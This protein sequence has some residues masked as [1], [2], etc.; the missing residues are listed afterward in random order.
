MIR[1]RLR[2]ALIGALLCLWAHSEFAS[3]HPLDPALLEIRES[4]NATIDVLWRIPASL[5]AGGPLKPIFPRRCATLAAPRASPTGARVTVRWQ[6]RCGTAGLVGQ[7][8]GIDGLQ[9]RRTDALVRIHLSDGRLVQSVLRGDAPFLAVPER[10]GSLDVLR[11]YL[12]LGFDHIQTG[13]DHLLFVLGLTLLVHGR[14]RLIWTITAFTVGH[15]VT[16]TLAVLGFVN[17]AP[18]PVEALIAL[19][20]FA[21]AVEIARE[22]QACTNGLW[23]YPWAM[24]LV[25]GF[26][27]GLGFAGALAELGLP[28]DEIPLAL[29][30]FNVG[31]EVGQILF[32]GL[33]LAGRAVLSGLPVSLP[34]TSK[35]IPAYAIGSLSALWIF[36]RLYLIFRI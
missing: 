25:F 33:V 36:E 30:S 32:V 12:A 23:R 18:A 34:K 15:S 6:M 1:K 11:N 10:A 9:E 29:F 17:V 16:L 27:H 13:L 22:T 35:M 20:I 8:I 14:R 21:V 28:A 19:S 5:P 4:G 2:I 7:R 31:I 24:A 26:L 3:A